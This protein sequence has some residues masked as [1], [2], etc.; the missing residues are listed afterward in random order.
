MQS[1]GGPRAPCWLRTRTQALGRG[2]Q[3]SL[4]GS[5]T[6]PASL[7][8]MASSAPGLRTMPSPPKHAPGANHVAAWRTIRPCSPAPAK[9]RYLWPFPGTPWPYSPRPYCYAWPVPV[10]ER[11]TC[12]QM[13]ACTWTLAGTS[14]ATCNS[15]TLRQTT[16]LCILDSRASSDF[17]ILL[18][19][20]SISYLLLLPAST[21]ISLANSSIMSPGAP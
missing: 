20:Y 10:E 14:T 18:A 11:A 8:R 5:G 17:S 4:P 21:V 6:R 1:L 3:A 19:L 2:G 16:S 9:Y 12:R 15:H 13:P 7:R